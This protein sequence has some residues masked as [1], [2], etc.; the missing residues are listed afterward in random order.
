MP[1][2]AIVRPERPEDRSDVH[3]VNELAFARAEEADLVDALRSS[4]VELISLVAEREREIVGHIL[5]SPV[6]VDTDNSRTCLSGLAPMAVVPMLQRTGIGTKL[7]LAGLS[8]LREK[9]ERGVVVLGHPAY[10][11]RFGFAP[12]NRFGLRWEVD[13]PEEAF[14]ALEL[15]PGGLTGV[16][17]VVRFRPE[18]AKV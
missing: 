3:R 5:F 6:A 4:G 11:P 15:K 16:R 10:Y 17:G 7:V 12:A 8:A 14:M 9:G 13:C 1:D 2:S 18:F